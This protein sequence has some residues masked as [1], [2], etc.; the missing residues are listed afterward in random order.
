MELGFAKKVAVVTGG[1]RGIG[2]ACARL[3]AEEGAKVA[4]CARNLERLKSVERE[5]ESLGTEVLA[6]PADVS[7]RAQV[8]EFMT[9]V[10]SRFGRIDVLVN[11]AGESVRGEEALT[12][13]GWEDHLRQYLHSAR[14]CCEEVSPV[15]KDQRSGAI[16]NI[17]SIA[18]KK[19]MNVSPLGAAK[20][21]LNNYTLGLAIEMSPYKVRV[22]AVSPGIVMSPHRMLA[23]GG[24]GERI[25]QSYN[26]DSA[27][28]AL[29]RYARENTLIGRFPE[30]EEVANVVVFLASE[31]AGVLTGSFLIVDGGTVRL[32]L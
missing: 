14:W 2:K 19:P 25:A 11:N 7:V 13:E 31:R 18:A 9:A 30:P 29:T 22:N 21:A 16:I 10:K 12:D 3:F 32:V 23:R 20:S 28:E 17:S 8:R 5:I 1:T 4:I 6:L 24:V 15:M 26:M 27:E